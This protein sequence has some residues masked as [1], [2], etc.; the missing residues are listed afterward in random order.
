MHHL[1]VIRSMTSREGSHPRA[2]LLMHT[3][4]LPTASVK[5]PTLGSVVSQQLG[6]ESAEL[7]NFVRIGGRN[8]QNSGN[9]GFLGS[10][11]DPFDLT[12]GGEAPKNTA[13][14]VAEAR[15]KR[16]L[17]LMN[18]LTTAGSEAQASVVADH[19]A[20]Y[21]SAAKMVLSPRM[22]VFDL[23]DEP[24]RQRD[25]YG[26]GNFAAGC[27]LA[28]RL[29]ETGVPFVEVN[30]N[31]WDTHKDNFPKTSELAGQ[32]DRPAAALIADLA[33]R[34]MLDK[35]LVI[36]MGEFGRTP[37]I[38]PRGGRDHY[39]RAFNLAVAGGGVSGGQVIG[40]TDAGGVDVVDRSVSVKDLFQTFCRGL[41]IDPNHENYTGT[42]RPIKIVD[43]GSPVEEL[44][45]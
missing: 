11:Y 43:E 23:D 2:S 22:R 15:F 42:G 41:D 34:G 20:L 9:A 19:K 16:R 28:R 33:E 6:D 40:A 29:V 27:L 26:E 25:A 24:R 38:N 39:P 13:A 18:R 1:A 10:K 45:G 5:Y 31:G 12:N 3:G 17:S 4:Y 7:P 35:T 14:T 32:V 37:R 8:L 21:R 30:L 36:W 44:F